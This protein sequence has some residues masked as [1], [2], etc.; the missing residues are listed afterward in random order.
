MLESDLCN[1]FLYGF[2][3]SSV[4]GFVAG[5]LRLLSKQAGQSNQKTAVIETKQSAREVYWAS[6]R[7]NIEIV[8]WFSILIIIVVAVLWA[9]LS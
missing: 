9:Y 4:L 3:A 1:F 5:R 6:I 2:L 7:A 8:L